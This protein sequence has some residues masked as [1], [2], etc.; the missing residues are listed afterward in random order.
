MLYLAEVQR[1][2][3]VIGRG[4]AEFKLLACQRSEQSWSAV[5]GEELI[6]A[7]DDVGYNSGALVMVDLTASRQVQRHSEA[8]RQLVSI[9]QNFSRLQEKAKTQEE[10]IEQWKQSLTYQSQ[11]LNRREME[12]E[13]RQEQLQSM[14][15]D[16]ERLEQQR[17]EI[18]TSRQDAERLREEFERKSQELE[19]AWAHLRGEMNR[20]EENRAEFSKSA[21]DEQKAYEMQDLLNRLSG[22]VAPTE[23]VREQLNF[24]FEIVSGHQS[25]LEQHL[26]GLE[27]QRGTAQQLQEEV[28]RQNHDVET[29][30][31]SWHRQQD[32]LDHARGELRSQQA[33]LDLKL[34]YEQTLTQHLQ[35]QDTLH[36]QILSLAESSDQIMLGGKVD[37]GVLD[38]MPVEELRTLTEELERELERVSRFVSSQEEELTLQQQT[39]D[40]LK[41]HIQNAND[42]DRLRLETELAD[43]QESYRMLNETLVG[44]R[45]NL[46]ERGQVLRQHQTALA[47]RTGMP[48]GE[49]QRAEVDM[50]PILGQ[51]ETLRQQCSTELKRL[52]D[53][54]QQLRTELDQTRS[55]VEHLSAEQESRRQTLR[56]LE[57]DLQAKRVTVADLWAKVSTYQDA[58]Q[59]LQ[60][61]VGGLRHHLDTVS[62]LMAQFQETSD[63]QLQAI[64]EM[65]QLILSLTS[66]A[67]EYAA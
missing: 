10:E 53:E 27:Q 36:Q 18:E 14:E 54:I 45:R 6:P 44:Q 11:E 12:M 19:G 31:E 40:D 41:Q 35:Q 30:W 46:H 15:E 42:F 64:A 7:P 33:A 17:Q 52:R 2:S 55:T 39:I 65:R 51:V 37:F 62:G 25:I 23:A 59:P 9:L 34:A 49:G 60:P 38:V 50:G 16:L 61:G 24:S 3:G 57:Q 56:Q 32:T 66:P 67:A 26:Q 22:A 29:G 4:K 1:K 48:M 13:A 47:R 20:F 43:E 21:L 8:G 58:L 28:D 5:P 63:Y